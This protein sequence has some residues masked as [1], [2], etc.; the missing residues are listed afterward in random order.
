MTLG[1]LTNKADQQA[2]IEA[3]EKSLE[4]TQFNGYAGFLF[5]IAMQRK[6]RE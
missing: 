3:G 1:V 6:D 5:R 4:G 2:A